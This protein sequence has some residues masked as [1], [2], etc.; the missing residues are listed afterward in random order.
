MP[1]FILD[2]GSP[3]SAR[4]FNNLDEFTQGY[5]EAM[6]FT[7]TGDL[8]DAEDGLEDANVGELAPSTLRAIIADCEAWQQ[9]NAGLLAKAYETGPVTKYGPYSPE[10][11]GADYWFSRNGHGA[12]FW[13]RELGDVGDQLHAA[14]KYREKYLYRGDD[15]LI[16]L[17]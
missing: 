12:G 13:D 3:E 8:D 16:Y 11:A 6:F 14:C 7:D 1:Q 15:G 9:A 10:R 4:A 2:T 17:D 5:I